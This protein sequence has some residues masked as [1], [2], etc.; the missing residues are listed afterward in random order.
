[1]VR[2]SPCLGLDSDSDAG[3]H[4][5]IPE[6]RSPCAERTGPWKRRTWV[7]A[8]AGNERRAVA[9]S[10]GSACAVTKM[11]RSTVKRPTFGRRDFDD[12][13]CCAQIV[14][15]LAPLS[16]DLAQPGTPGSIGDF[17]GGS[18]QLHSHSVGIDDAY[19]V[20]TPRRGPCKGR[21]TNHQALHRSVCLP[22]PALR[23]TKTRSI[24]FHP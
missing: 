20:V 11:A 22:R 5:A 9:I 3:F 13:A 24:H 19:L 14:E 2:R 12:L 23:P 15:I 17:R 7:G 6:R 21:R 18:I 8:P 1:M 10:A 4:L 16:L